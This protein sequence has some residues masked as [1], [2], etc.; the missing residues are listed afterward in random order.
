M[1]LT[2]ARKLNFATFDYYREACDIAVC[3]SRSTMLCL[4]GGCVSHQP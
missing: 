4:H 3:G 1:I 2:V